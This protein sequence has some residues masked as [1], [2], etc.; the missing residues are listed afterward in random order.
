MTRARHRGN[1]PVAR[2]PA[3]IRPMEIELGDPPPRVPARS[4]DG[5]MDASV[6]AL[7]RLHGCPLGVVDLDLPERGLGAEELALAIDRELGEEIRRHLAD[8]ELT[9]RRGAGAAL[10]RCLARRRAFRDRAPRAS[11]IVATRERPL[12]LSRCLRSLHRLDYPAYEVIVVD[13]APATTATKALVAA[14]HPREVRYIVE[15]R[16]G[17]A[18]AHNRGMAEARGEIL[19]FTDDDVVVDRHWLLELAMGFELAPDVRCVTGMIVAAELQTRAQV[20]SEARW[21]LGKGFAPRVFR[22]ADRDRLGAL[23]PFA[24]GRFGSGAN[25][26]FRA[27]TL[28]DLG[29]FDPAL[30]TGTPAR[31]GDDLA[32][33]FAVIAAGHGLVYTPGAIVRHWHRRDYA[34]LRRQAYGYG[35]GLTAY[36]TKTVADDPRRIVGL[37]AGAPAGLL[38]VV[39]PRSPK[40]AATPADYPRELRWWELL[41]MLHGPAGYLRARGAIRSRPTARAGRASGAP[42]IR[43][44]V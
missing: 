23:F 20:W 9:P 22:S 34:S 7:V 17:L 3:R 12:S 31:G 32:T 11:V 27:Q 14:R 26:A 5:R 41:G 43:S 16:P 38:H 25:M 35:A 21:G 19:A 15:D 29:G 18:A 33:F 10:P 1:A 42:E 30:G 24:A 37:A 8:D 13:N 2:A 44:A 4:A 6:R 28:H 36:L 39:S 40:N